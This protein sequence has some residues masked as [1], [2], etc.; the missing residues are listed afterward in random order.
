MT[1]QSAYSLIR[2]AIT[3]LVKDDGGQVVTRPMFRDRPEGGT[4]T[5]PEPLAGLRATAV[6][7]HEIGMAAASCA[8]YAREDGLAWAEIGAALHASAAEAF[9]RFAEDLGSGLTFA[10]TCPLCLRIVFDRG[11]EAGH[12][13]D[14]EPGHAEGCKRLAAAARDYEEDDGA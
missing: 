13:A 7:R 14:A 9:C 2:G 10:W 1:G 12:P 6:L 4:V 5:E 8:R 3:I 11:P